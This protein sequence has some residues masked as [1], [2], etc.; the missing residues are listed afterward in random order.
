MHILAQAPPVCHNKSHIVNGAGS[1]GHYEVTINEPI[2]VCHKY[3]N[4][5]MEK[6]NLWM[7]VGRSCPKSWLSYIPGK[8]IIFDDLQHALIFIGYI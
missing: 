5:E 3:I 7:S 8:T 2:V 4:S 1:S 6:N